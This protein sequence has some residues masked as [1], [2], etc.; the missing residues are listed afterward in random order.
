MLLALDTATPACTAALLAPDG[1][2]LGEVHEVMN[3][4]HAERLVPMLDVLLDG[5][6]ADQ[7]L[8]GCGPGSFTGL[9]VGI[10]AAQGLAIGWGVPL[11]GM[12]TLALLAATAPGDGPVGV[13]LIGGHGEL[14]AQQFA[15]GPLAEAGPLA[16]LTPAKAAEA[17]D[18]PLVVGTGARALVEAR[19]WGE[20]LEVLPRASAALA[21][22]DALRSLAP[23]PSYA[24]AP[25]AK[26]MAA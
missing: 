3:R 10:S 1:T 19:G 2:V 24:R 25:D 15:R 5:R 18:A 23:K 12:S 14:F 16:S 8:V 22:P 21:L 6:R 20:V 26:P 7:I 4:G 11:H 9:R 17:I 13:A